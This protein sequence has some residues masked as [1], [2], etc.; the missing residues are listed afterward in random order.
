[1]IRL[2]L[3]V[4]LALGTAAAEEAEIVVGLGHSG[5][6]AAAVFSPGDRYVATAGFDHTVRLWDPAT[7]REIRTLRG[8]AAEVTSVAFS[9]DESRL[10]SGSRDRT[11][12]LWDVA[13]G[14]LLQELKGHTEPVAAVAFDPGGR[15]LAS[16]G[17]DGSVR[18]WEAGRT[19]RT[20]RTQAE[21]LAFGSVLVTG[22]ADGTIRLWDDG[23]PIRA[24]TGHRGAVLSVA[25]GGGRLASGGADDTVRLW[26]LASGAALD[27]NT[28]HEDD[29][30]CV[31]F[32]ASGKVLASA[33][34]DKS[35][36]IRRLD[37][38]EELCVLTGPDSPIGC[39]SLSRT[40]AVALTA[41]WG[42]E[43]DLWDVTLGLKMRTLGGRASAVGKLAFGRDGRR[44]V[45]GSD[46]GARIW[47]TSSGR[48]VSVLGEGPT[49]AVAISPKGD[50]VAGA[51]DTIRLWEDGR[52][53]Y[54][55]SRHT[56]SVAD[57][58]FS[59]DG[60][61]LAS[62]GDD[63]TVRLWEVATG[64]LLRTLEG[65]AFHVVDLDFSPDGRFLAS[66]SYDSTVMVWRVDTGEVLRTLP[67]HSPTADAVAFGAELLASAGAD[68]VARLWRD[69]RL[70]RA[71]TGHGGPLR[72]VAFT[73]DGRLL[74]GAGSGHAV[75]LWDVATGKLH[76]TLQGH[77]ASVTCVAAGDLLA[78][79][80]EDG[81]IRLWK[82]GLVATLAAIGE[83]G[84][85]VA[86]TPEGHFTGTPGAEDW[87]SVRIGNAVS[88]LG[89]YR[90]LFYRPDLVARRL[91]GEVPAEKTARAALPPTSRI[92]TPEGDGETDAA[93]LRV[94][95]EAWDEQH[96][97]ADLTLTVNGKVVPRAGAL[98]EGRVR[99]SWVVSLVPGANVLEVHA[100]S[101][102]GV[103]SRADRRTVTYRPATVALQP[104][105]WIL[106]IAVSHYWDEDFNLRFP[107]SDVKRLKAALERQEGRLYREVHTRLLLDEAVTRENINDCRVEFLNRASVRDVLV[108][109]VA[110]HGVL[111]R[112]GAF[113]F[114]THDTEPDRP[115]RRGYS[116]WDF[117][118]QLLEGVPPQRILM[119]V[120]TCHAGGASGEVATRA[121]RVRRDAEL[122]LLADRMKEATGCYLFMASTT[123]EQALEGARW[124]GGLFTHA[125]LEVLDGKAGLRG[126]VT[127][128]RL[129]DYVDRR[130][131]ELSEG[132]Q[133][134]VWK[135]PRNARN[136][137]IAV[138]K[139]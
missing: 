33:S 83:E 37:T 115:H 95:A 59:P 29:V 53:V 6:V 133:H 100:T 109:L 70:V 102:A 44:L 23:R 15:F 106:G 24:L 73:R 32:D 77:S 36:R 38:A 88:A 55:L 120:D 26:D 91:G 39:V 66:A 81:T 128:L 79:A 40:G 135:T 48:L 98:G 56:G 89:Q 30:A 9:P 67:G 112:R 93:E 72:T 28:E 58:A 18:V 86:W 52:E 45:S 16:A 134:P 136:F 12:R 122:D 82:T 132:T 108:I 54:A 17:R 124:G 13:T 63:R 123:K 103:R 97:I 20:I 49:P 99:A 21:S 31:A 90:D 116:W 51:G 131:I 96:A 71:L 105:L 41:S 75:R 19:V 139:D 137:P 85:F 1:M 101:A 46:A 4:L 3:L 111:D 7:G 65:H 118:Q 92:V 43:A 25:L 14:G 22:G 74:A 34:W 104:D 50:L 10:A 11:V 60:A 35:V 130:V 110:G 87:V 113:Y 125:L 84:D 57:V 76:S 129:L 2:G 68:G 27:V 69:D 5:R 8:H 42:D 78:S 138:L 64:R 127:V 107:V 119:L 61:I 47:D 121:V 94:V 80:G 62:A 114:V 126:Q 117:Q